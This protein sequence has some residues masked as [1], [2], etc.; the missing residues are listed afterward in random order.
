[1]ARFL[2][3][4]TFSALALGVAVICGTS[5]ATAGDYPNKPIKMVIPWGPGGGSDVAGRTLA[6]GTKEFLG[7]ELVSAN[8]TGGGGTVAGREVMASK[9]DGYTLFF[10]NTPMMTAYHTGT[11]DFNYDAFTPICGLLKLN[12]AFLV[13]ADEPYKTLDE[14]LG[15]ARDNPN[16]V[17][18]GCVIGSLSHYALLSLE[19]SAGVKFRIVPSGG[20]GKRVV[21]LKGKHIDF[22]A[23]T[24][25]S[26][27]KYID[28]GDF[29]AIAVA[30]EKRDP[31]MP[32]IPTCR[33]LGY[34]VLA[35]YN[36]YMLA[37][38]GLDQGKIDFLASVF[39]KTLAKP[40]VAQKL[41]D[42]LVYPQYFSPTEIVKAMAKEN[43]YL[44]GVAKRNNIKKK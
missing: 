1:M 37:P 12:H 18:A 34:E 6:A 38:K 28:S 26:I 43:A 39:E 20:E 36:Y 22:T 3:S 17:K 23:L 44:E 7:Q 5:V 19:E 31:K 4:V 21:A 15:Y 41:A 8:V 11:A 16:Q 13:R 40:E 30:D 27:N 32:E 14:F 9:P 42:R 2:R 25:A 35:P 29:R 24:L 33:E 10:A